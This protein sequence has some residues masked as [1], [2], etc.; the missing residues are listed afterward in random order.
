MDSYVYEIA[1]LIQ[2]RNPLR[3]YTSALS[4]IFSYLVMI[5]QWFKQS[6]SRQKP[7]LL[8]INLRGS[9]PQGPR[10]PTCVGMNEW[11]HLS[12]SSIFSV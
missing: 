6:S 10:P 9:Y 1:C 12:S 5:F 7:L 4:N 11:N 2:T 8:P 3:S